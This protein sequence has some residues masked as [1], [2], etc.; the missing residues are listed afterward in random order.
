MSDNEKD[1]TEAKLKIRNSELQKKYDEL[2]AE[3]LEEK[4][5]NEVRLRDAKDDLAIAQE[6]DTFWLTMFTMCGAIVTIIGVTAHPG[7]SDIIIW[8]LAGVVPLSIGIFLAVKRIKGIMSIRHRIARLQ[9]ALIEAQ[10]IPSFADFVAKS[11]NK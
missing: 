2:Y 5:K 1:I 4:R 8:F 9:T 10:S 3:R 7:S 11:I 6:K